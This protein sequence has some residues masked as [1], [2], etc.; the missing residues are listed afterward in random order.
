MK[1]KI[2]SRVPVWP[3]GLY[4]Q[5]DPCSE[6]NISFYSKCISDFILQNKSSGNKHIRMEEKQHTPT[7]LW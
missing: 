4:L 6:D 2:C 5:H 3:H 7:L 1:N